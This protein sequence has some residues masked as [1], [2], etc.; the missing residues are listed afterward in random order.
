MEHEIF[1]Y[2]KCQQ[3]V[4]QSIIDSANFRTFVFVG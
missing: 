1:K 4:E 3:Q 2:N